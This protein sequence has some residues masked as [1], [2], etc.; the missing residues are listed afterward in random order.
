MLLCHQAHKKT[1]KMITLRDYQVACVDACV[2]FFRSTRVEKPRLAVAPTAAGKSIIVAAVASEIDGKVLVLQPSEELLTQNFEKYLLYDT[3]AAVFS[4]SL[5]RREI[6]RVTFATIGTI[7]KHPELFADFKFMIM[8]EAHTYP[9][10]DESMFGKFVKENDQLKILGL[11]AT[12]FRLK[13]QSGGSKLVMMHNSH[14]FR[15]YAHIIQIKDIATRY[16]A[17]IRYVV[18][19]DEQAKSKLKVNSTG[20]DFTEKS[21]EVFGKSVENLIERAIAHF[22]NDSMLVFV[23]SVKDAERMAR[24][25]P[26]SACVSSKTPKTVRREIIKKFKAGEIHRIFNF[27]VL[28]IGFDHPGLLRVIDA[29]PTLSLAKHYQLV[30]RLTRVHPDGIQVEKTYMD[31]AGNAERFGRIDQLDIRMVGK[32][33]HVFNGDK[34]LTGELMFR[35]DAPYEIPLSNQFEDML[36]TFGEHKDKRISEVP[37]QYLSWAYDNATWN[38]KLVHHIGLFLASQNSGV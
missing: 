16:W 14:I 23:P 10:K 1:V 12:P 26:N 37:I 7:V 17:K 22:F 3:N 33:Y 2:R 5:N 25:Y 21:L 38:R 35:G 6:A 27:G 30:G 9:A 8:D 13:S 15:G 31:F 20:A 24:K 29:I 32:T 11:T 19:V 36:L 34:K 28:G 4:A 18:R